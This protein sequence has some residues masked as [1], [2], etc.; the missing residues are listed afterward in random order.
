M[1]RL[2]TSRFKQICAPGSP[3]PQIFYDLPPLFM[4]RLHQP[5]HLHVIPAHNIGQ[6]N[7]TRHLHQIAPPT[8]FIACILSEEP[9]VFIGALGVGALV[10]Q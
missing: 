5:V 4:P 3:A 1:S 2:K 6:G 9:I 8:V 7:V 10:S